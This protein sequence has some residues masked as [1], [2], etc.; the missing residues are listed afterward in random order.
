MYKLKSLELQSVILH[1]TPHLDIG[2]LF[3]LYPTTNRTEIPGMK[4]EV[5]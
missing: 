1:S 2:N 4:M 3:Y 5:D